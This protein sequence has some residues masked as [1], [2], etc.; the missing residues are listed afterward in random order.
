MTARADALAAIQAAYDPDAF[1]TMQAQ[2]LAA[3]T[4]ALLLAL[5]VESGALVEEAPGTTYTGLALDTWTLTAPE[6]AVR[7]FCHT[8]TRAEATT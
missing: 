1:L 4:P 2:A 7:V 3:L 5:A 6:G 8:Q